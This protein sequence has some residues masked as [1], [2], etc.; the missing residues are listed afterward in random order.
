MSKKLYPTLF[1]LFT[2]ILFAQAPAIQWQKSFGGDGFDYAS[3]IQ[4][5]SDGGYIVAGNSNS[6]NGYASGNHG[7]YDA[8]IVKLNSTGAIQ[9][10]K[11]LGGSNDDYGSSIQQTSDQGY[12]IAGWSNSIDGDVSENKGG[13]DYWIVKLN[14]DGMIQWQKSL[15]GSGSN[16]RA[17]AIQQTSDGGYIVAGTSDSTNGDVLEN[18]GASDYWIVKLNAV[19]T[20]QWQKSLGGNSF[21]EAKSIKQTLDGGYI[22]AGSSYSYDATEHNAIVSGWIIK[23]NADGVIEWQKSLGGSGYNNGNGIMQ[24]MDGGYIVAGSSD[25][26]DGTVNHGNDDY[27]V[28]KLN[29]NGVIQ[30]QKSLGGSQSDSAQSIQQTSDEGYIVAGYSN[31]NNGNVTGNHGFYDYWIVKLN[32][33]GAIQ[34]Q[35][36]L[37]GSRSESANA[38]HQTL[39]GGYIIAGISESFNGDIT[40]NHG[41]N[42]D[43][44]IVKLDPEELNTNELAMKTK[45]LLENPVKDNLKIQSKETIISLQLYN[46]DGQLIK[47]AN[48]QNMFVKE[49]PKGIYILKIH[50]ENGKTISEKIIKE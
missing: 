5:T 40:L 30:W 10:Q 26:S 29:N 16:D 1:V 38:I 22:V 28:I 17:N 46:M 42:G 37:G 24:T 25:S 21:D 48:S 23:L 14:T 47:I 7:G 41:G 33:N 50:F 27:W 18:H 6:N 3:D 34:W 2:A 44:W 19:G 13:Y 8:W 39:D 15:G 31:S 4:L 9:W 35:K 32:N 20:I 43:Y 36:S 45:V 11:S 49:L 12:I